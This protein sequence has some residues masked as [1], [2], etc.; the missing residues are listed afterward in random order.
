MTSTP[1]QSVAL[2][3]IIAPWAAKFAGF[4]GTIVKIILT[5]V[6]NVRNTLHELG[7]CCRKAGRRLMVLRPG[8]SR[9]MLPKLKTMGRHA[10]LPSLQPPNP[11]AG[12]WSSL[13]PPGFDHAAGRVLLA[14]TRQGR[15]GSPTTAGSISTSPCPRPDAGEKLV[16]FEEREAHPTGSEQ[17]LCPHVKAKAEKPHRRRFAGLC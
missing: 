8:L 10:R 14:D 16:D 7:A 6:E 11:R 5:I 9:P 15:R 4:F 1:C 17:L 3:R 2:S 12:S 13:G